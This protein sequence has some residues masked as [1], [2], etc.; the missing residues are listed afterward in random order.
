MSNN[1]LIKACLRTPQFAVIREIKVS[2][3]KNRTQSK[4]YSRRPNTFREK[5][6]TDNK[7]LN[8]KSM[9]SYL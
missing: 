1:V 8:Y 5:S 4:T 9:S 3:Q 6:P 7:L 2:E